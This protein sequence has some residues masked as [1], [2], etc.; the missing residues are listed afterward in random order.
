MTLLVALT[1]LLLF[2]W[3]AGRSTESGDPSRRAE[4]PVPPPRQQ[5]WHRHPR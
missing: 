4:T 2:T 1:L 5:G 3:F